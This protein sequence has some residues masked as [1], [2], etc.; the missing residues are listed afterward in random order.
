MEDVLL[1]K[2]LRRQGLRPQ[3]LAGPLKISARRW[4]EKGI[5][6]Q[7]IKNWWL[8]LQLRRGKNPHQLAKHYRRHDG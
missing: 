8:L 2:I 1:S 4:L 5:F 7:T 6:G 3:V